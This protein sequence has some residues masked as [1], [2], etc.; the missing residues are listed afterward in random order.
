MATVSRMLGIRHGR[1]IGAAVACMWCLVGWA[2]TAR[3]HGVPPAR[4]ATASPASVRAYW[5]PARMRDAKPADALSPS[6]LSAAGD[7]AVPRTT[8]GGSLHQ[9]VARTNG[10][11]NRTEGAVF[12]TLP[13]GP[14]NGGD[15][16]CSGTAVRSASRSLVWTAGHCVFDP[17]ALGAGYATHWEFVPGYNRGRKPFGAW[18]ATSL[19]TTGQWHGD[20]LLGG[21]S[22]FDLGAATVSPRAGKLLQDRIGARRMGFGQP[23]NQVYSAFGYPAEGPPEFDGGHLF[24][25]RSPYRGS[26]HGVGPP[27]PIRISCDMTGGASGG[28]WVVR[29]D[30]RGYVVSVT[31]YGYASDRNALYGPYQGDVARDLRRS[32]GGG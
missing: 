23:R 29:R 32:A 9:R 6:P 1:V 5:T 2:S 28:A 31:S 30:G 19:A 8:K 18:P 20:G 16:R 15:Y 14:P 27:A 25:C 13:G 11:P 17:G 4:S 21:N 26:D 3:A 10:Y 24:R 12:F 7:A 22:A